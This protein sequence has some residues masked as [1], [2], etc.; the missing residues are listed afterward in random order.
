MKYYLFRDKKHDD[1]YEDGRSYHAAGVVDKE[2][3]K[4]EDTDNNKDL[5]VIHM[6]PFTHEVIRQWRAHFEVELF[7]VE[8]DVW[9]GVSSRYDF[10]E[11]KSVWQIDDGT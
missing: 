11:G 4:P 3:N 5:S 6:N 8:Y 9:I 10:I 1:N 2:F 7:E